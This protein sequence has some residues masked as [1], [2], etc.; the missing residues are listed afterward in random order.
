MSDKLEEA[1]R[2]AED[3]ETICREILRVLELTD[4]PSNDLL[5]CVAGYAIRCEEDGRSL[6]RLIE[7]VKSMEI[8]NGFSPDRR[9]EK[10]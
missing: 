3:T 7:Q 4:E 6:Q 9:E 8:K 2:K 10:K 1:T 5:N